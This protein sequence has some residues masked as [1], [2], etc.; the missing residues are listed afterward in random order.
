MICILKLGNYCSIIEQ[1]F[2]LVVCYTSVN[3]LFSNFA[4]CHLW[5][6]GDT[7]PIV[8]EQWQKTKLSRLRTIIDCCCLRQVWDRDRDRDRKGVQVIMRQDITH[9]QVCCLS[10]VNFD[11]FCDIR[12][13]MIEQCCPQASVTGD[14]PNNSN[15]Y[16][17]CMQKLGIVLHFLQ[18]SKRFMFITKQ[19]FFSWLGDC[20]NM[21]M[22]SHQYMHS[23]HND[24]TVPL[25]FSPSYLYNANPWIDLERLS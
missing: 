14:F 18:I 2:L 5:N 22:L 11:N 8:S 3:I 10:K 23:H 9:G 25:K 20:L 21:K 13:E 1:N 6:P 17:P 16:Q 12:N 24:K 4:P 7:L 19:N 15:I